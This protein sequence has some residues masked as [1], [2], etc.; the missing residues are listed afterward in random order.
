RSARA[1]R[2]V[3]TA[4]ALGVT[5]GP[6]TVDFAAVMRRV[7]DVR[8]RL[9]PNDSAQ[10]LASLGVEVYFGTAQFAGPRAVVV[11]GRT[12]RF[13]RAVIATGG[14][15]AIPEIPGLAAASYLTNET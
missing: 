7:R 4:S 5:A 2:D 10:R 6:A 3:R 8:A 14:R 11:E 9:A 1:V 15:P 12:L 13:R